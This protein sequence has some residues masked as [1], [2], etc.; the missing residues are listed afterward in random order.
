M[1]VLCF[2]NGAGFIGPPGLACGVWIS[3]FMIIFSP[4]PLPVMVCAVCIAILQTGL[5]VGVMLSEN[6]S[7]QYWPSLLYSLAQ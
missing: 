4:P 6:L 2:W 5:L 7:P 1:A 3:S